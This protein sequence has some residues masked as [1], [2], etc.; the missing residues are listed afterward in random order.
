M[1]NSV[2]LFDGDFGAGD[3]FAG[4]A[5]NTAGV[6]LYD[7]INGCVNGVVAAKTRAFAGALRKTDLADDNL[8]DFN[9]LAT[10]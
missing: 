3:S 7:A 4:K 6:E 5:A 2:L 10:I 9:F 1:I 8:A